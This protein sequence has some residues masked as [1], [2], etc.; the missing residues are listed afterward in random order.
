MEEKA[1]GARKPKEQSWESWIDERIRAAQE[2][3]LFDDLR[4]KGKPL[5]PRRNPFLPEDQQLAYDLLHD[6][7]HTLPWI[8]ERQEIERRL[9][10]ARETLRQRYRWYLT[11]IARDARPDIEALWSDYKR[12]FE[13]EVVAINHLIDIYNLKVP[14]LQLQKPRISLQEEYER[15]NA[16]RDDASSP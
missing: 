13:Q 4:G 16:R 15:L 3:G 6:S 7:G 1:P 9:R 5:P 2:Q 11:A 8:D 10:Q 12:A 14:H